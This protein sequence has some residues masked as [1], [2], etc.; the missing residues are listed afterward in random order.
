MALAEPAAFGRLIDPGAA[1]GPAE[2]GGVPDVSRVL[3]VPPHALGAP[4]RA[5][6][7]PARV[8]LESEGV[9]EGVIIDQP[10][11]GGGFGY[12]PHFFVPHLDR[13]SAELSPDEKNAISHRG[14]ALRA[15]LSQLSGPSAR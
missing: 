14:Q 11:G 3:G 5:S 1:R 4:P 8:V 7:E 2:P 9:V 6:G 15:M 10:R 12:D 13:T